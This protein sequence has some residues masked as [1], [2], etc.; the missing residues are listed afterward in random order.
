M[1]R[2]SE[3]TQRWPGY[4]SALLPSRSNS[5]TEVVPGTDRHLYAHAQGTHVD[6]ALKPVEDF[7]SRPGVVAHCE[8]EK[9]GFCENPDFL[10]LA[11]G[12]SSHPDGPH[13]ACSAGYV[14]DPD[15]PAGATE[16]LL[17]HEVVG[18]CGASQVLSPAQYEAFMGAIGTN[19]PMDDLR[20][21]WF[22]T[23]FPSDGYGVERNVA[24]GYLHRLGLVDDSGALASDGRFTHRPDG[25]TALDPAWLEGGRGAPSSA[26]VRTLHFIEEAVAFTATREPFGP[27]AASVSTPIAGDSASHRDWARDV[28]TDVNA[29]LEGKMSYGTLSERHEAT[30]GAPDPATLSA[31]NMVYPGGERHGPLRALDDDGRHAVVREVASRVSFD[32]MDERWFADRNLTGG[33]D[34]WGHLGKLG[35]LTSNG[36]L[37]RDGWLGFGPNDDMRVS[38]EWLDTARTEDPKR[39]LAARTFLESAMEAHTSHVRAGHV[40]GPDAWPLGP[41]EERAQGWVREVVADADALASGSMTREQFDARHGQTLPAQ[42]APAA[43]RARSAESAGAGAESGAERGPAPRRPVADLSERLESIRAERARL[44]GRVADTDRSSRAPALHRGAGPRMRGHAALAAPVSDDAAPARAAR[45]AP[46]VDFG[47]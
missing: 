47:R 30:L 41:G 2:L 38:P 7:G 16:R 6:Q 22:L 10:G 28:M 29:V 37:D 35:L 31:G 43:A 44:E 32:T 4:F 46:E 11:Y 9:A 39:Y 5:L 21:D 12:G 24:D 45:R 26:H 14:L 23:R 3:W 40:A 17:N 34:A 18:H 20:K 42:A 33:V 13:S 1:S 15:A 25:A 36:N 19:V 27:P 8:N